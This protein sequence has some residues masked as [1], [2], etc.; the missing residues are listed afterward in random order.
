[1]SLGQ[2]SHQL[3]TNSSWQQVTDNNSNSTVNTYLVK[4]ISALKSDAARE[5]TIQFVN[6]E[7]SRTELDSCTNMPCMGREALVVLDTGRV[8]KVNPFTPDYNAI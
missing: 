4:L 5:A 7:V 1:M 2:Q 6:S 3:G 8:M